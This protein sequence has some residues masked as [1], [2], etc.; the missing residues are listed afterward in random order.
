VDEAAASPRHKTEGFNVDAPYVIVTGFH[1]NDGSLAHA[2]AKLTYNCAASQLVQ[3]TRVT[4]EAPP[5]GA[6]GHMWVVQ[7][8]ASGQARRTCLD[9]PSPARNTN[10]KRWTVITALAGKQ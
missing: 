8:H 4:S 10:M 2:E 5:L 7:Q 3:H 9:P 1:Y 6:V